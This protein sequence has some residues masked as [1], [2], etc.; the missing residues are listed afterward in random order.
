MKKFLICF[1]PIILAYG[2]VLVTAAMS[3]SGDVLMSISVGL[4]IIGSVISGAFVALSVFRG[5]ETAKWA[6][7]LVSILC[8][9]AVG[10]AYLTI[11]L[12]G[13]CGLATNL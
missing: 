13:C 7:I 11:S 1:A 6:K 10:I 4:L 12:A 2:L 8:S 3:S 9:F 5:M